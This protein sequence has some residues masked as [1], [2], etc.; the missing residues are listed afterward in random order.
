MTWQ[1]SVTPEYGALSAEWPA[2]MLKVSHKIAG[3]PAEE[4]APALE[5]ATAQG[6]KRKRCSL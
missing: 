5:A 2:V 6:T 1:V 4:A 3:V